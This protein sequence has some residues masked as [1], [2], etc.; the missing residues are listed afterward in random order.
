ATAAGGTESDEARGAA[1]GGLKM[2]PERWLVLGLLFAVALLLA[3][4][5]LPAAD[6]TDDPDEQVLKEA[7]LRS[8]TESL[9][10]WLRQH[11]QND[12]DLLHM[13]RL[14]RDLGS[15]KP[16]EREQATGKLIRLGVIALAQVRAAQTDHDLE[17]ARRAK[18]CVEEIDRDSRRPVPLAV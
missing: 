3:G 9:L 1:N 14:V 18:L 10:E 5:P 12:E 2:H 15:D 17:R 4:S 13:D 11:S 7:G 16:E 6:Q 8:G